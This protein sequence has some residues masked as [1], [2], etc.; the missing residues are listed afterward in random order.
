MSALKIQFERGGVFL[1]ELQLW[2][3]AHEPQTG[4]EKVFVSHAHADHIG[5]HRE[6][7][8]TAPTV[9]LMGARLG[10][11]RVE[12]VLSFG[13]ARRFGT[14]ARDFEITLCPAGH[15][16][17]SAMAWVRWEGQSLLYTGDFKLRRGRSAEPCEPR[18]A[19]ILIMETTYGRPGYRFPPTEAVM[20][21]VIRFC[22]EALDNDETAVLLGYSLGKS[23]EL[24]GG[25]AEA[26]LPIMLHGAVFKLTQVYEQLGQHFPNY[27]RYEP[28]S[29]RGKVLLCPPNVVNSVMLRNLGRVRTAVLT[30]WAVD[31][32]CRFRYQCDA[33]FPVSDHADF[34][35][36]IEMVQQVAPKK[37]YTLPWICRGLR[38]DAPGARLQC[39]GA[40]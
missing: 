13:E 40:Q 34:P 27:E 32:D 36:L 12:H 10:G 4:P 25:L 20:Q 14:D 38:A 22:R 35:D 9:R 17:G 15:I 33:A 24:L 3:D 37:V 16:F 11:E 23:Q 8:L 6:V 29:A 28:G 2:L 26:S 31:P 18:Q 5:P 19:D 21:G 39:A 7:I 30:G 1:P